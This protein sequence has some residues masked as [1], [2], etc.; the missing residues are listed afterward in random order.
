MGIWKTSLG[1]K[2]FR[3]LC[4]LPLLF[5]R[6]KLDKVELS[7]TLSIYAA[8]QTTSVKR[9]NSGRETITTSRFLPDVEKWRL[10][11]KK[12]I[13][14]AITADPR[15]FDIVKAAAFKQLRLVT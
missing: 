8:K 10:L 12:R 2:F 11:H 14:I 13:M 4:G 1:G 6:S 3:S 9:F 15:L 7:S 5:Q